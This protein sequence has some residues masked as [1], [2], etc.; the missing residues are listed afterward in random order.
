MIESFRLGQLISLI[1]TDITKFALR[2]KTYQDTGSVTQYGF[3]TFFSEMPA[4]LLSPFAGVI[5]DRYPRKYIMMTADAATAATTLGLA[6]LYY[7]D[8]LHIWHIY[9]ANIVVTST[10]TIN[11]FKGLY[12]QC[13]SMDS[14]HSQCS[15]TSS[16]G[17]TD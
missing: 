3:L 17:P 2:I 9:L 12:M 1:G 4:M 14:L 8:S 5:V 7:F 10:I 16:Q 11:S 6:L 15:L 13:I